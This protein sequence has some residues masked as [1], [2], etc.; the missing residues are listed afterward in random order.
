MR[1]LKLPYR[2]LLVFTIFFSIAL[3]LPKPAFSNTHN[4][5]LLFQKNSNPIKKYYLGEIK[6]Y[7]YIKVSVESTDE[8]NDENTVIIP[9]KGTYLEARNSRTFNIIGNYNTETFMWK[10]DCFD[11]KNI[12]V[13]TFLGKEDTDGNIDGQW[14]KNKKSYNFYL[15]KSTK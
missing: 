1:I 6:K 15:K 11:H 8:L 3:V 9:V 12:Y 13:S 14:T 10:L 7:S 2:Q 5:A 4:P